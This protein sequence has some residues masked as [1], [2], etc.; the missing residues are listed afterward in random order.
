MPL[1][2]GR[3]RATISGNIRELHKG[4]QYERTKEAHGSET[5]NKQAI[6]IALSTARKSRRKGGRL[7]AGPIRS[8]V[9]GRTDKHPMRVPGGSYVLPADIVSGLGDGNTEAGVRRAQTLFGAS[10]VPKGKGAGGPVIVASGGEYVVPPHGALKWFHSR[11]GRGGLPHAHEALD[12]WILEQ[13]QNNI[14]TLEGLP[15]PATD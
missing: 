11:G 5:A 15:P 3:S 4:P 2:K 7:F 12:R 8:A 9:P 13:R 14:K 6:A 10:Y 1:R